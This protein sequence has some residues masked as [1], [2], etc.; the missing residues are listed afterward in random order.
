MSYADGRRPHHDGSERYVSDES[1]SVGDTVTVFVRTADDDPAGPVGRAHAR[2][3]RD[4]EPAYVEARVDRR[5][6][7]TTWWRAD[8]PV[9][10]ETL[11]YRFWLGDG[12]GRGRW[13]NGRGTSVRD[14]DDSADFRVTTASAPPSWAAD[15]VAYQI[16]PDRFARSAAADERELP[17]WAVPASW[18]TPVLARHP[19]A[20]RQVYGG[21]LDG[22]AEHLDHLTALGVNLIYLTPFFPA[23]SNHRYDAAGFDRV[24]PLLGGDAALARL[25][26]AAHRRG[27]RVIGDITL[28]HVGATHPWFRTAMA[29]PGSAE[30]GFFHIDRA[31][32]SYATFAGVESLPKLDHTSAELRRR[33]YAGRGSVVDR[34]L[35]EPYGLD[36][37]RVD[38]AHSA[39]KYG[40]TDLGDLVGRT[41]RATLEAARPDGLL[42]AEDQFDASAAL[43][44]PGWHGTMDYAGFTRP[45]WSWLVDAIGEETFWGTPG[46]V[47]DY[48]AGDLAAVMDTFHAVLPWRSV[49]H[50][51]TLIDCHDT[52]RFRSFAGPERQL[53]A[54]ALMMT[55]PG[56][57]MVFAGDEV[58]AEGDHL[59]SGRVPFRWDRSQW[60][61]RTYAAYRELIELRRTHRALRHG[62]LRWLHADGDV[63]LF[64]R[65][66]LEER[67]LVQVSRASHRPLTAPVDCTGLAGSPDVRV[68]E[69]L[70]GD[71]PAHHVWLA[72]V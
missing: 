56:I 65:E 37:W 67:L 35:R 70:P 13:L 52:G 62:G 1:P 5:A 24:D 33:L 2:V 20:V 25:T 9:V 26:E 10:N 55:L 34:Y 49:R 60:D 18:D 32:G 6:D 57:P 19:D 59:E 64:E 43:Q 47:P 40:P 69:A 44:G 15:S 16:F 3:L 46:P 66:S 71:G 7:G 58:G 61:V 31:T 48:D 29:D 54:A 30:N 14:V 4:G 39:G 53:V 45:V 17:D 36:G 21:D 27:I 28:N 51:L 38:V 12:R 50:N 42:L 11:R 8:L 68:G 63:V 41:T 22:V 23:R 72:K